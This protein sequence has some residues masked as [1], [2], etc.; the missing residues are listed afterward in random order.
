MP[1]RRRPRSCQ[2]HL[3]A[4]SW[5]S[6]W[7]SRARKGGCPL[8]KTGEKPGKGTYQCTSCEQIVVLNEESDALPPCPKCDGTTYRKLS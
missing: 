6:T 3:L 4:S 5:R 8:Y 7:K 2:C 1:C